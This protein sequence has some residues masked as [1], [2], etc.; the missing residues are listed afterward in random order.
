[1]AKVFTAQVSKWVN[2]SRAR[3]NAVLRESAKRTVNM[4]QLPIAKG[5]NM[6]VDTGFLRGSLQA[7]FSGPQPA[8]K[9]NPGVLAT[10]N[11]NNVILTIANLQAG[12]P[13]LWITYTAKY[14]PYQEYGAN[15]RP[16][17]RFVGLAAM[18]WKQTVRT[19]SMEL[20][21]RANR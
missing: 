14:A 6:P 8:I 21:K 1:M 13:S 19:V 17:R 9:D 18:R 10:G 12:G 5:G 7:S 11:Y 16:G 4:M 20:Q 2:E 15:G 3:Q